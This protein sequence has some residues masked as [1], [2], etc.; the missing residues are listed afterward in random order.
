MTVPWRP[1]DGQGRGAPV[2]PRTLPRPITCADIGLP[3]AAAMLKSLRR[4]CASWGIESDFDSA[5]CERV[6]AMDEGGGMFDMAHV[7]WSTLYMVFDELAV[8]R[9]CFAS[10][11]R[12]PMESLLH[13][14]R[15]ESQL[16]NAVD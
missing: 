1:V 5:L 16:R 7:D 4:L 14:E 13:I 10:Q 6:A 12:G 11:H 9:R 15:A 2:D 3:S 8:A